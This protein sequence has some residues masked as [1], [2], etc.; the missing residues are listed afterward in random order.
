MVAPY[1]PQPRPILLILSKTPYPLSLRSLLLCV[2]YSPP[3]LY[4]FYI[5]YTV[6]LFSTFS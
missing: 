6:K 1:P 5:S 4:I 2:R 3:P